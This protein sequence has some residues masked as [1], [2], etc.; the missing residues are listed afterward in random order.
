MVLPDLSTAFNGPD[1][2]TVYNDYSEWHRDAVTSQQARSSF[3][4]QMHQT[5][6]EEF[7]TNYKRQWDG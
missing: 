1:Y 4:N 3:L 5:I 6:V 7:N 2:C